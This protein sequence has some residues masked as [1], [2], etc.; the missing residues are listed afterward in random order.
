MTEEH[1]DILEK[2]FGTLVEH[3]APGV[4]INKLVAENIISTEEKLELN[5]EKVNLKRYQQLLQL[6]LKREDR[7]FHVFVDALKKSCQTDLADL[8]VPDRT[9]KSLV[10]NTVYNT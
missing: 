1:K 7:A 3:L 10:W 5:A 4:L 8:L 2:N 9:G 6:L